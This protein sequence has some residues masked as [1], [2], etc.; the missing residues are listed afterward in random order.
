MK[1][2]V[3]RNRKLPRI[4]VEGLLFGPAMTVGWLGTKSIRID[5][6]GRSVFSRGNGDVEG[7]K[8]AIERASPVLLGGVV[9]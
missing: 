9:A 7:E 2:A 1:W 6:F 8:T 5:Q 3:A 4:V